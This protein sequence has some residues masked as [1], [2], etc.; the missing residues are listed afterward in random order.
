MTK[1]VHPTAMDAAT[2][3]QFLI[4]VADTLQNVAL[5]ALQGRALERTSECVDMI[6]RFAVRV[7]APSEAAR[8]ALAQLGEVTDA[9]S[10]AML[11][12][13]VFDAEEAEYQNVR[14][15]LLPKE[16]GGQRRFDQA[17]L[18]AYLRNSPQGSP[19]L[20]I[21]EARTLEGGRS[22]LTVLIRQ[23]GGIGLPE[24]FVLRQDWAQSVTGASVVPEFGILKRVHAAGI[25]VPQPILLESSP[26]P[27]GAPFL[28]V[29]KIEGRAVGHM[30]SPPQSETLALQVAEQVGR[31]HA[32]TDAPFAV[33]PDVVARSYGTEQLAAELA[34][35]TQAIRQL[36]EPCATVDIALDWLERHVARIEGPRVLVHGDL[37]FHN[38]LAD[39]DRLTALLDWELS[40]LGHPAED[41]GYIRHWVEKMLPWER[42]LSAYHAAGGPVSGVTAVD[43]YTLWGGIRL[44][45]MLLQAR[46]AIASGMLRDCEIANA[47]GHLSQVHLVQMSRQLRAI[48]ARS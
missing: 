8:A 44:Y 41:L 20:Q 45:V 37:G 47:A 38:F 31:L 19:V 24:H 21:E 12:G 1:A 26:E 33:L 5:P 18:Q 27:V 43:F 39:G 9:A 32:M 30:F 10:R 14:D 46:A 34:A 29:G 3:R 40:H 23:S 16:G 42:F 22:K 13:A 6:A 25:R 35:M 28:I 2:L 11:D 7:G 17:R 15:S 4:N 36:G 48:L